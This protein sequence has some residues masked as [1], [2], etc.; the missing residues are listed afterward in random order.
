MAMQGRQN[1]GEGGGGTPTQSRP[2]AQAQAKA[3]IIIIVTIVIV[4]CGSSIITS[5]VTLLPRGCCSNCCR[6][7]FG[8]IS[9]VTR[10]WP[11]MDNN[12][13][14]RGGTLDAHPLPMKGSRCPFHGE[15]TQQQAASKH[16]QIGMK[17]FKILPQRASSGSASV[18]VDDVERLRF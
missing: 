8:L 18:L 15:T 12:G 5:I 7:W 9:I 6:G 10:H 2:E 1:W 11:G 4:V 17:W 14:P 13:G 16:K 3:I